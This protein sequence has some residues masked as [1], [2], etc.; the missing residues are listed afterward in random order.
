MA[1]GAIKQQ[2][3]GRISMA[4]TAS[5][6]ARVAPEA[7]TPVNP[8]SLL[9]AVNASSDT[10]HM[11]WLLFLGLMTY[12]TIAVAGVSHKDLLLQ[13]P[14]ALPILQVSIQQVQ[15]F[16]F[17]PVLLVLL[18]M[19]VVSQLVLVAKKTLEFDSA[20]AM[21]ESTDRRTHPL[22]LELHNFFF[23]QAIAGPHR[24]R[25]MS[26]FLHGMSWLTLVVLPV[27]LLLF[28]QIR[29]LPFHDAA[30][31]WVHR[32]ALVADILVLITIGI[33]LL[34]G[35]SSFGLAVGRTA[36]ERPISF[37]TTSIV[38]LATTFFS[39]FVA[40]IPG[41]TLDRMSRGMMGGPADQTVAPPA[42]TDRAISADT[43]PP[44]FMVGF[45]LPFLKTRNDG[46]LFGVFHRNLIAPDVDF[47][48]GRADPKPGEN[49]VSLRGRDLRYA[50]L[51][52][53][54]LAFADLT[55]ADLDGASLIATDLTGAK[56]QCADL[57]ELILSENRAAAL[58]ASARSANFTRAGLKGARM[59]G[60]DAQGA[61]F[62]EAQ[63]EGAE[64]AY[65]VLTGANFSSAHMERVD[66]TGGVHAEGTNFLIASLQ[67]A[68][69]TGSLLHG[70]DFS[71]AAMQG[72]MLSHAQLYGAALRD[73]DLEG[74]D[75][76]QS[77]LQGA[78]LTGAKLRAGD[79]RGASLWLTLPPAADAV[80]NADLTDL[81]MKPL[82]EKDLA[83]FN[84]VVGRMNNTRTRGLV[85]DALS[86]ISNTVES[87]KWLGA[88]DQGRWQ[89]L[90]TA[91]GSALSDGYKL[92]I[93][94]TLGSLA[95]K[96][97]WSS[98]HVATG[99][100]KRAQGQLFRGD[101]PALYDR[102][103]AR[104]CPAAE[105]I[106]KKALRDLASAVDNVRGN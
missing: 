82:D 46:S 69:L 58:C 77:K 76:N 53:S 74:A 17:A 20:V 8:Y 12:F 72:V 67:G 97:R 15:F 98:G 87:R 84:E 10:A 25:V 81:A 88:A 55:G 103:R 80:A 56:L 73:V 50:K 86:A 102:L 51:D 36:R 35:E 1:D 63:M 99:I 78:D 16:Q 14:V 45:T 4:N 33:F 106:A 39:F 91:G 66:M 75:L 23:V 83:A 42:K 44:S 19:G 43:K 11:G 38:F 71:S 21:L 5:H 54:N 41:E 79:L 61:K 32:L 9:D 90:A 89:A 40:T 49:S 59:S 65:S 22:R 85:K 37:V 6:T 31:T 48:S 18:H 2:K 7:E 62:E 26:L 70:A 30:I 57:N 104:E 28:I 27:L 60:I 105:N 92:R 29:Y 13:T 96:A 64:L 24:S 3:W 101:M 34:R 47:L 52:R 100:A 68:D 93:T 94:D 95:C